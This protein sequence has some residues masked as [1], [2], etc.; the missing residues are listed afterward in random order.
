MLDDHDPPERLKHA[1][2]AAEVADARRMIESRRKQ[3]IT[4]PLKHASDT[5]PARA[6]RGSD[7]RGT[8]GPVDTGDAVPRIETM[9]NYVLV[10][11]AIVL[12]PIAA[13]MLIGLV[14]Q[15][16][17]FVV[18][19]LRAGVKEP[20]E[21][22]MSNAWGYVA[23]PSNHQGKR[24]GIVAFKQSGYHYYETNLDNMNTTE[25]VREY[26][27]LLNDR[28]S[29]PK[30]V[31]DAML[32]GVRF[33]WLDSAAQPAIEFFT[34]RTGQQIKGGNDGHLALPAPER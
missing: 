13:L 8:S 18:G 27:R 9:M 33:G 26:V 34:G 20:K 32:H 12:T 25:E 7:S 11:L 23:L 5:P 6:P 2:G 21:K 24:V 1:L 4:G 10:L 28:R 16:I 17:Y 31:E 22:R 15:P 19:M 30:E 29:I 14:V 3:T